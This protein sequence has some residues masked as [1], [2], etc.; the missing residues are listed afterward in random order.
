MSKI[1]KNVA[2]RVSRRSVSQCGR[3]INRTARASFARWHMRSLVSLR[4]A[5]WITIVL[6]SALL[7]PICRGSGFPVATLKKQIMPKR[8]S[9]NLVRATRL[10][11]LQTVNTHCLASRDEWAQS[12]K[13]ERCPK[14]VYTLHRLRR[15]RYDNINSR[16]KIFAK[17]KDFS[18]VK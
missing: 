15:A 11:L 8:G 13:R 3:K 1:N 17:Q 16:K 4:H 18:W 7:V 14:T 2:R 9:P 12:E 10:E 6:W 5:Q